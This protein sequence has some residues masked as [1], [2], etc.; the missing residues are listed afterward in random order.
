MVERLGYR[1]E[2][3]EA[4]PSNPMNSEAASSIKRN[5][6]RYRMHGD[7]MRLLLLSIQRRGTSRVL[8]NAV[9]ASGGA[10]RTIAR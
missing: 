5:S 7:R 9:R 4:E 2:E 10:C 8:L 1:R 3:V 6:F